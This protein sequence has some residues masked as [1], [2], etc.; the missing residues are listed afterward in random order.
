MSTAPLGSFACQQNLLCQQINQIN[1]AEYLQVNNNILCGIL[2]NINS[3]FHPNNDNFTSISEI[4]NANFYQQAPFNIGNDNNPND[5]TEYESII[6]KQMCESELLMPQPQ[7]IQTEI[8]PH[9]RGM[10]VDWLCRLHYKCQLTTSAF[11]RCIG[12][13]DRVLLLTVVYPCQLKLIGCAAML[14]ATKVEGKKPLRICHAIEL[15][16]NKFSRE[17]MIQAESEIMNL[18]GF[19]FNFPTSFMFLSHLM[20]ISEETFDMCLY[21]RNIIEVCSSAIEF[22]NVR[23]SAVAC[24][25]ILTVRKLYGV[26]TW[27]QSLMEYTGYNE[28]DLIG[29]AR[30]IHSILIDENREE[31]TFMR[32]KY[33][34]PLFKC[35]AQQPLPCVI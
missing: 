23:P 31:S 12:I 27:P 1:E 17:D 24:A 4:P 18:L 6:Y 28:E 34:S 22:I 13:I 11:Y 25:A 14:I 19:Q 35:V 16:M 26:E 30:I 7:V 33:G 8:T 5:A 32:R 10:L 20:R 21:A 29:Y 3:N 2:Q 9:D 15:G